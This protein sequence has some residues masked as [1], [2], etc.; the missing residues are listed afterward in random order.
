MRIDVQFDSSRLQQRFGLA[1]RD[2][3]LVAIKAI[4]ETM[5]RIQEAEIENVRSKFVVR[6][7]AFLFGTPARPGGAAARISPF[8]S[9]GQGRPYAEI[10]VSASTM[11]GNRRL[12]LGEFEAG[13]ERRPFTP[14]AKA[15]AIPL[16]GRPARPSFRAGV[17]YA[18]SFAGLR[19]RGYVGSH[20][21]T[22]KQATLIGEFGRVHL[23]EHES[24]SIQWK[25][26]NRTFILTRTRNAPEGGVFE[27]I[28]KGRDAIRMIYA[29]RSGI[30]IDRRL[31][32]IAIA[33]RVA[34]EW[35]PDELER[36]VIGCLGRVG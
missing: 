12:L 27:R 3:P 14:G 20:R 15:V 26:R 11:S 5:L 4:N 7:P 21:L 6:K 8:A 31:G 17:P 16:Q 2:L 1:E 32:F 29:F 13:G 22:R 18:Y 23:P 24:N 28:G 34:D 36:R 30:R 10:S 25:G 33:R 19:F 9:I 35:F